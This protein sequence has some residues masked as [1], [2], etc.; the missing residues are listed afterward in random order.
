MHACTQTVSFPPFNL[1][2]LTNDSYDEDRW[3][4]GTA[5]GKVIKENPNF[6]QKKM[7]FTPNYY[8]GDLLAAYIIELDDQGC[9]KSYRTLKESHIE[10]HL[11]DS[12]IWFAYVET[13]GPDAV[14]MP[15]FAI[16]L[17]LPTFQYD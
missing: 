15:Y 10:E 16:L 7:K 17:P 2:L 14:S 3:P 6:K 4:S 13:N 5:G 12:N 11:T 9:L 1:T 8:D